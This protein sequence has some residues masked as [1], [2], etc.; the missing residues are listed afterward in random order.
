M[1]NVIFAKR[2][3]LPL[4]NFFKHKI[5]NIYSRKNSLPLPR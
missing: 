5:Q 2:T 1:Y 3:P 4:R